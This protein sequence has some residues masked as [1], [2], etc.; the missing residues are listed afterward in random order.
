MDLTKKF[1]NIF[2][3]A[4]KRGIDQRTLRRARKN[5]YRYSGGIQS[6]TLSSE[7][8]KASG[9]RAYQKTK[10]E[11]GFSRGTRDDFENPDRKRVTR[12]EKGKKKAKAGGQG[13]ARKSKKRARDTRKKQL[14]VIGGARSDGEL[15]TKESAVPPKPQPL[16]SL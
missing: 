3:F 13:R 7:G 4:K 2:F 11:R 5:Q 15:Q 12:R 14:L 9:A 6:L 16:A 8:E 10:E 1:F